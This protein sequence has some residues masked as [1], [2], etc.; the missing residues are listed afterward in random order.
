MKAVDGP[1]RGRVEDDRRGRVVGDHGDRRRAG[2]GV[3]RGHRH[4]MRRRRWG[5]LAVAGEEEERRRVG[6]ELCDRHGRRGGVEGKRVQWQEA[7]AGERGAMSVVWRGTRAGF[8]GPAG[9]VFRDGSGTV[10]GK[11]FSG[12]SMCHWNWVPPADTYARDIRPSGES[13]DAN[14]LSIFVF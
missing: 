12:C 3:T 14:A 11:S 10:A 5:E 1:R 13:I 6:P 7:F 2:G 8:I 9:R 4:V